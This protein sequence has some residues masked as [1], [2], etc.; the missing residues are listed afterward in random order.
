[1]AT[2]VPLTSPRTPMMVR[3]AV[4]CPW[5]LIRILLRRPRLRGKLCRDRA[6]RLR[7][8]VMAGR[9]RT[10]SPERQSLRHGRRR[11][12]RSGRGLCPRSGSRRGLFRRRSRARTYYIKRRDGQGS[13]RPPGIIRQLPSRVQHRRWSQLRKTRRRRNRWK[14]VLLQS[15][16][17]MDF[18][19]RRC[20][21]RR[22]RPRAATRRPSHPRSFRLSVRP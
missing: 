11:R 18:D 8:R 4:S 9:L 10:T 16:R 2:A 1:M 20:P 14:L 7:L 3:S 22:K 12:R 15:A 19:C 21:S 17:M 5:L 6:T 13:A